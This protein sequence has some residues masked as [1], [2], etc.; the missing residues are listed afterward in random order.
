MVSFVPFFLFFI[1]FSTSILPFPV[2]LKYTPPIIPLMYCRRLNPASSPCVWWRLPSYWV[3]WLEI[4]KLPQK[5]N[6]SALFSSEITSVTYSKASAPAL[7]PFWVYFE[8]FLVLKQRLFPYQLDLSTDIRGVVSLG[9]NTR[10]P[11][12][13]PLKAKGCEDLQSLSRTYV[14]VSNKTTM[15][16][17]FKF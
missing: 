7:I 11:K 10:Q 8:V 4:Q 12:C 6:N 5:S 15:D 9:S 13:R 17:I 16:L 2:S 3:S 14:T 1:H